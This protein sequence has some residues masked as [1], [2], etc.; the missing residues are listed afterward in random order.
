[1]TEWLPFL[2]SFK[3]AVSVTVILLLISLPMA[4]WLYRTNLRIKPVIEA[5]VSLPLVLPPSVL[6]FYFLMAFGPSHGIGLF[7]QEKLNISLLFSFSGL[8]AASVVYSLPF[9]VHPLQ[10]G[11]AALPKS[12][13]DAS[14]TLGKSNIQTFFFV[15]LP[16]VKRAVIT[17]AVL[18]FAHTV[19]EFGVVLMIGGNIPEKTR[20]VSIAIYDEA[21]AMNL[22]AA[23]KYALIL[24]V[25]SFVILLLVYITN[26][27]Q[28]T[29]TII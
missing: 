24:T 25:L 2:L 4:W 9:M 1:M 10:S 15:V 3:L 22:A 6:G 7:L 19:G 16:N 8:V 11:F 5:I 17:G 21:E 23:N 13:T 14:R 28:T 18:T 27:R 20:V 26:H 12:L 29:R